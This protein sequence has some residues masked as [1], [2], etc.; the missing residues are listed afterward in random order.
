MATNAELIYFIQSSFRSVWAL[1][2]VRELRSHAGIEVAPE[3]LVAELRASDLIVRQSLKDLSAAGIVQID[4]S[5]RAK[6]APATTE[7]DGLVAAA[8]AHYAAAPGS[9]RR[10]ILFA[11]N[12]DL[13]AFAEAFRLRGKP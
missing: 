2:V 12:R 4:S 1:E 13:A 7:L 8:I 10:A 6:Y 9:V 3:R 5:G 11:S